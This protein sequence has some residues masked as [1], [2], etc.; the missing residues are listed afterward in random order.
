MSGR[1]QTRIRI[2]DNSILSYIR[3]RERTHFEVDPM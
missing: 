3:L 1:F 2:A